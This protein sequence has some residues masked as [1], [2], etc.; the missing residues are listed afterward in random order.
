MM[1]S[2]HIILAL[3]SI[4]ILTACG[5]SKLY[6]HEYFDESYAACGGNGTDLDAEAQ[7]DNLKCRQTYLQTNINKVRRDEQAKAKDKVLELNWPI[8]RAKKRV[9]KIKADK[10]RNANLEKRQGP[11][12]RQTTSRSPIPKMFKHW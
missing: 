2:I 3:T 11:F 12:C 9:A 10:I 4:S 1:K 6:A 5:Q 8:K 7:L